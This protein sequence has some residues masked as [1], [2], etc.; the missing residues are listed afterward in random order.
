MWASV[1]AAE[2]LARS[3]GFAVAMPLHLASPTKPRP[4]V[5]QV[6]RGAFTMVARY[7]SKHARKA[8]L[9]AFAAVLATAAS[10]GAVTLQHF[11]AGS[12]IIPM[13]GPFQ[14]PCG[15]VSA[16]G[17]VYKTLAA[18]EA[19]LAKGRPGVTVH[20]LYKDTSTGNGKN[21]PN[22]C[23]PTNLSPTPQTS[24]KTCPYPYDKCTVPPYKDP[25]W[26]DGCDFSVTY[27]VAAPVT[28]IDNTSK[29]GAGL[30]STTSCGKSDGSFCTRNTGAPL[31]AQLSYPTFPSVIVA[32]PV[33]SG[34]NVTT[35]QY[36]G[37]T[38]VIEAAD[39]P[40][41]LALLAGSPVN[42]LFGNAVDFST[43]RNKS[44][45]GQCL[46]SAPNGTAVEFSKGYANT[47]WVNIHRASTGFDAIDSQRMSQA[48]GK[49]ALLQTAGGK[50]GSASGTPGGVVGD[51][52]PKYLQSA[53]LNFATAQGCPPG[54][55]NAKNALANCPNGPV[56]GRIFDAFDVLD[57]QT[58]TLLSQTFAATDGSVRPVYSNFWA[59]HWEGVTFSGCDGNCINSA[60]QTIAAY[61]TGAMKVGVLAECASIGVLEGSQG[62]TS[63][64]ASAA[65]NLNPTGWWYPPKQLNGASYSDPAAGYTSPFNTGEAPA[66]VMTC[67]ETTPG[68]GTCAP[69]NT[70]AA[71]MRGTLHDV[72][73]NGG[74]IQT[75]LRNCPDP[76]LAAGSNCM[77]F[78][79]PGSPYA[80]IGDYIWF[81]RVG[82][83]SN[84]KT[85]SGDTYKNAN[86]ISHL[87]F[88][89]AGV[90]NP[91]PALTYA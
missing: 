59:P 18:S 76:G 81:S 32:P 63:F 71:A 52:L 49:I 41:F 61:A 13:E 40:T 19:Q 74:L 51:M 77:Y 80:Q 12:L 37:G 75:P 66:K 70:G 36:M 27:N 1:R 48:P 33:K 73:P 57:L 53:G 17:L 43:F 58:P 88:S 5:R 82:L 11:G 30:A 91:G 25:N 22:R 78:G 79:N 42:D 65:A 54:G 44:E 21:S 55:Y 16:Y 64:D 6:P 38:F 26:N 4:G 60:R 10:A 67:A 15:V 7:T 85:N 50:W 8:A 39:A 45:I 3:E 28:L 69:A 29:T 72:N 9:L 35:M 24:S 34:P 83:V 56:S 89:I 47:H 68:S 2:K 62:S 87:G 23:V 90:K 31:D 20:W 46:L 14:D 84:F 86:M